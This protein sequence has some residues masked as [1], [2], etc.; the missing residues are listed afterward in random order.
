VWIR[1]Y[2]LLFFFGAPA[3]AAPCESLYAGMGDALALDVSATVADIDPLLKKITLAADLSDE[4][5]R[6][7]LRMALENA[8]QHGVEDMYM[9]TAAP[10]RITVKKSAGEAEIQ[11]TNQ[12]FKKF[13][14]RLERTFAPGESLALASEER[15][16]PRGFG[17]GLGQMFRSFSSMP[18]G[19]EM[20][21]ST[22][23][24]TATFR[25]KIKLPTR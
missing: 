21:W 7:L 12:T 20:G 18:A 3:W 4:H 1:I 9:P 8:L 11:I 17:I 5:S 19:S 10:L 6:P 2:L 16:F 22:L 13:P 23:G 15:P 14:A 24:N 25:L